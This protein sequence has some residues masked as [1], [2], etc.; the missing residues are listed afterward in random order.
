MA[1]FAINS[2]VSSTTEFAPFELNYGWMPTMITELSETQYEGV[3][4]FA[5]KALWNLSAAHDAII[6]HRVAQIEQANKLR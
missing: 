5:E 4:Q 3:K 1:K 2:T 6:T